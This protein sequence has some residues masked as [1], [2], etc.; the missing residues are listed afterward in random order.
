MS[1]P[2]LTSAE[3]SRRTRLIKEGIALKQAVEANE[4]RLKQV[5]EEL[6]GFAEPEIQAAGGKSCTFTTTAGSCE[7]VASTV[8]TLPEESIGNLRALLGERSDE[9]LEVTQKVSITD[10]LKR[11]I[12]DP[13]PQE[14]SLAERARQCLRFRTDSRFTFKPAA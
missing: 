12:T 6:W 10:R 5:K 13:Q 2:E 7:V 14:K 8:I 11:L 1:K 9:L 3:K 4:A